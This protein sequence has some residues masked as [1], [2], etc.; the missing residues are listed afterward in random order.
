MQPT[1]VMT[2]PGE[3]L[4]PPRSYEHTPKAITKEMDVRLRDGTKSCRTVPFKG[5][6]YLVCELY[7]NKAIKKKKK[8]DK[9]Q[10]HF[11]YV[12]LSP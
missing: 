11:D 8:K 3:R 5:V 12:Q 1:F 10:S 6:N 2:T 7:L 9:T 4:P